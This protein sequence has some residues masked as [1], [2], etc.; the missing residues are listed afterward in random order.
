MTGPRSPSQLHGWVGMWTW[1]TLGSL[2][3][4]ALNFLSFSWP[5]SHLSPHKP[6]TWLLVSVQQA[7]LI[8]LSFHQVRTMIARDCGFSVAAPVRWDNL[9]EGGLQGSIAN[10]FSWGLEKK[11]DLFLA[12]IWLIIIQRLPDLVILLKCFDCNGDYWFILS[13]FAHFL[14]HLERWY[15]NVWTN[16]SAKPISYTVPVPWLPYISS[17]AASTFLLVES[18]LKSLVPFFC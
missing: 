9:P 12:N 18:L 15:I 14:N 7:L 16:K 6:I 10:M 17:F 11:P 8:V 1:S 4:G 13:D 2:K 5:G 3:H